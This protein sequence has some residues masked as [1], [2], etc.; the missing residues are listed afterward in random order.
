MEKK[1]I[2][3][4]ANHLLI[5]GSLFVHSQALLAEF[6][7]A[8][9]NGDG[10]KLAS[11]ID[12][13]RPL[14]PNF[15]VNGHKGM[16][17]QVK[18]AHKNALE[19]RNVLMLQLPNQSYAFIVS[20]LAPKQINFCNIGDN[21]YCPVIDVYDILG[22]NLDL[23]SA[24]ENRIAQIQN[25]INRMRPMM[26]PGLYYD[27]LLLRPL[28]IAKG[29]L[30]RSFCSA[31]IEKITAYLE[32]V[33]SYF[34]R[35][36]QVSIKTI[37]SLFPNASLN[38]IDALKSRIKNNTDN[39]NQIAYANPSDR[40]SYVNDLFHTEILLRYAMEKSIKVTI[41]GTEIDFGSIANQ[42]IINIC[43]LND[44]CGNCEHILAG[45]MQQHPRNKM[46]ISSINA[47]PHPSR[48]APYQ[49]GSG[50][51]VDNI[52]KIA[53]TNQEDAKSPHPSPVTSSWTSASPSTECLADY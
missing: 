15:D 22:L 19:G 32:S 18:N 5:V 43:S 9:V 6:D 53:F 17:A 49:F 10:C 51:H 30:V 31:K 47:Y 34:S 44:M 2:F 1:K 35:Q 8:A 13:R 4:F 23:T 39:K 29:K 41:N 25:E 16:C 11:T 27:Q 50:I 28:Q 26:P 3:K 38:S 20:G 48:Y 33:K 21:N 36:D 37:I 7:I 24:E 40:I 42:P 46:Y 52:F 45:F 12:L 14:P